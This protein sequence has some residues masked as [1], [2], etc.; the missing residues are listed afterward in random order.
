MDEDYYATYSVV[1]SVNTHN[2]YVNVFKNDNALGDIKFDVK[3]IVSYRLSS[4]Q[5]FNTNKTY[6]TRSN[7]YSFGIENYNLTDFSMSFDIFNIV[8]TPATEPPVDP[9]IDPEEPEI[10]VF[11]VETPSKGLSPAAIGGIV[12]GVVAILG[13]TACVAIHFVRRKRA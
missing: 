7:P 13:T 9:E 12:A 8:F 10:I 5:M 2:I 3:W 6:T 1:E 11:D 4:G